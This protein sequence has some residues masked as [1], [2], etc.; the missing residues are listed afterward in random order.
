MDF[1][2]I[3]LTAPISRVYCFPFAKFFV[4][5]KK[6]YIR[7][8]KTGVLSVISVLIERFVIVIEVIPKLINTKRSKP[9]RKSEFVSVFKTLHD[10]QSY[11]V[12][13]PNTL[14]VI[15]ITATYKNESISK[16]SFC[17]HLK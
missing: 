14:E 11:V 5:F 2:M 17:Q 3:N 9:N 8:R 4:L 15:I 7:N 10:V 1:Y 12:K 6:S 16:S 13:F